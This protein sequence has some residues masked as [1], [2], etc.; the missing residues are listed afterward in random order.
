VAVVIRLRRGGKLK[1]PVYRIVASESRFPRDGRFLE[2]L[3]QYDPNPLAEKVNIDKERMLYWL[4]VGALPTD[5]LRSCSL[6]PV[7]GLSSR[8]NSNP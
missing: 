7:Y 8:R 5:K 3:G 1:A 4:S 2:I 6:R